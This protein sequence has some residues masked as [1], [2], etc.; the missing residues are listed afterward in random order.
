MTDDGCKRG[1]TCKFFHASLKREDERCY[2]CGSKSH[3]ISDCD[4]PKPDKTDKNLNMES[5]VTRKRKE[6][7]LEHHH[8]NPRAKARAVPVEKE[9]SLLAHLS[10]QSPRARERAKAESLR[11]TPKGNPLQVLTFASD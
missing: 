1:S 8:P 2:N 3:S 4:R 5:C 10:H 6:R 11:L 9:V 7:L